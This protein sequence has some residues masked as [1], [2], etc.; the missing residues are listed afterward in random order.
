MPTMT[1][2]V[3]GRSPR[4]RLQKHGNDYHILL[5]KRVKHVVGRVCFLSIMAHT[6]GLWLS[7]HDPTLAHV[8]NPSH[9][10]SS[11][12]WS[13]LEEQVVNTIHSWLRLV[14]KLQPILETTL[15]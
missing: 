8:L 14:A 11:C 10:T 3:V 2:H 9:Q 6:H 15:R 13:P 4:S 1:K 5:T 7:D 12:T